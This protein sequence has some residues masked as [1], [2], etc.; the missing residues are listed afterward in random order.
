M[1]IHCKT[2]LEN[3]KNTMLKNTCE[4]VLHFV[5]KKGVD[6][7][8]DVGDAGVQ[9]AEHFIHIICEPLTVLTVIIADLD[10]CSTNAF[11]EQNV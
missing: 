8:T 11:F 9:L 2:S 10:Y 7:K 5:D 3:C 6:Y 1:L 4:H